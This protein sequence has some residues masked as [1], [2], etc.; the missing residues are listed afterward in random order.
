MQ[1]QNKNKTQARNVCSLNGAYRSSKVV[2]VLGLF[3]FSQ[4]VCYAGINV[5]AL[6]SA[7]KKAENSKNHPYGI[8]KDYCSAKTEAKCRKGC[9]QTIQ[10][11]LKLW[12]GTG[13]FISYLSGSYAPAGVANDPHGLNRNWAS[14]VSHFYA[15]EISK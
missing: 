6:A 13:D 15:K 5:E 7:I 8:L 10:K 14:N 9:V 12:N 11:R 1:T 4:S 3:L 2:L